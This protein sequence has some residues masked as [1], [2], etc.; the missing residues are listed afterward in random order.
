[1]SSESLTPEQQARE[2]IDR[3]LA[4][5][6]W[7]VQNKN[8][9]NFSAAE[10]IS[11]REY[12]TN[13]GPADYILF[14]N[15]KPAAVIEAKRAEEGH[16]LIQVEAQAERYSSSELQYIGA[17]S[18]PFVYES[19]GEITR[20]TNLNDPKPRSREVFSFHQPKT[21]QKWLDQQETLRKRLQQL[22]E[23]NPKGLRDCQV[24]AIRNLEQ[25]FKA[26]RPRALIQM[27]TGA[28]KTFTA[29]TSIYRLLKYA[30][31]QR[32]LFLVDTINLGEQ[33]EQEFMKYT[34][35]GENRKFTELY[36]VQHLRSSYIAPDSKVCISTIQRMYSILKGEDLDEEAERENPNERF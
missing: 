9:I 19:N 14:V 13:S 12:Q 10:G 1:M 20:F 26:G 17:A 29:I 21:L 30:G 2:K 18:L 11:I 16:R 36:P 34:P 8:S 23:L 5:P 24:H 22:P 35:A 6:G 28:G 25:S 4:G 3:K 7:V 33:A 31:A 15:K 27:A 32:I